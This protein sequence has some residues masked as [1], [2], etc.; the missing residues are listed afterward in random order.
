MPETRLPATR[1]RSCGYKPSSHQNF[2]AALVRSALV[3]RKT[4]LTRP[5]IVDE[6]YRPEAGVAAS[7]LRSL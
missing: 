7:W 6:C 1:T 2:V 3:D 5:S 4:I